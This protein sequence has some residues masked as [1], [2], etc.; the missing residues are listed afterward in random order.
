MA[1][2]GLSPVLAEAVLALDAQRPRL[3]PVQPTKL[4]VTGKWNTRIRDSWALK[5]CSSTR[6][7]C[8]GWCRDRVKQLNI[9][10]CCRNY[11]MRGRKYQADVSYAA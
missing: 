2:D 6:W 8:F 4:E 7:K 9:P 10:K 5:Q 11:L 3:P 1:T